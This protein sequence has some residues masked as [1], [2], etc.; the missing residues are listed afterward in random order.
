M[1][2]SKIELI[3]ESFEKMDVGMLDILLSNDYTYEDTTKEIFLEKINNIFETFKEKGDIKLESHRGY[4]KSKNCTNAGC[5]GY[6]FI[7]SH[8]RN[9]LDMIFLQDADDVKDMFQCNEFRIYKK[10]IKKGE[11]INLDIKNDEKA[12]FEPSIDFLIQRQNCQ[13]ALEEIHAQSNTILDIDTILEWMEKHHNLFNS[14][15]IFDNNYTFLSEFYS[16]YASLQDL[17]DFLKL[18]Y[19][20]KKAFKEFQQ[21][22]VNIEMEVL[23]WLIKYQ[24]KGLALTLFLYK[25]AFDPFQKQ[26]EYLMV[27]NLK[28]ATTII[29]DIAKFKFQ[30]DKYYWPMLQKYNTFSEKESNQ[31]VKEDSKMVDYISDLTFHIKKRGI[32]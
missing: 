6:S 27:D 29:E 10:S 22:D 16:T 28:I 17:N 9:F 14:L 8:S 11:Y 5:T 23:K 13:L 7:G 1:K 21:I 24:A 4:C 12:N 25:E 26:S 30:F 31:Y 32:L 19:I 2:K 15:T 3:T 18:D 20:S